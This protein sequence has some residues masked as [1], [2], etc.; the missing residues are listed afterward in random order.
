MEAFKPNKAG[1]LAPPNRFRVKG[2][3][4]DYIHNSYIASLVSGLNGGHSCISKCNLN[5]RGFHGKNFLTSSSNC[6]R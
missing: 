3:G 6:G 1:L 4:N 5:K 2:L